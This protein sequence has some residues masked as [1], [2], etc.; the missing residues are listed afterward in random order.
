VT[1]APARCCL[2]LHGHLPWVHHPAH[3]DFLEEDWYFEACVETYLPLLFIL[4]DLAAAGVPTPVAIG[5]TP[6]LLEMFRAPALLSKLERHL[7]RRCALADAEVARLKDDPVAGKT[8]R[9]YRGRFRQMREAFARERGDLLGAFRRHQ[10]A[11]RIEILASCATHAVLPLVATEAARRL[12]VRVGVALY[13]EAFGIAPRG[14]WL[15]ECAY[16]PG[17]DRLLSEEGLDYVVFETHGVRGA[18]PTSPFGVHR[19][20]TLPSGLKALGRDQ[21]S[22]RQVWSSA[23]GYPGDPVYREL[24]RD[25]GF[26]APYDYVKPWL[27]ADGL[28]RNV[29][30]KYHRV[31]GKVELHRKEPYDVD[32][33]KA[34]AREHAAHFL[35]SRDADAARLR[36]RLGAAPLIAAPY[37]LELFGHW[38][39]EGPWFLEA[40]F[41]RAAERPGGVV[42]STPSQALADG[43]PAPRAYAHL[44]TWGKN[45]FLEMWCG[46]ETSWIVRHQHE[47]ERRLAER[48]RAT[49]APTPRAARILDQMTREL[50]LAQ[51]SDWAFILSMKTSTHYAE[52][53]ARGHVARFLELE[54]LLDAPD[55]SLE[56]LEEAEADDSLFPGLSY[57]ALDGGP[58]IR[59][60][61]LGIAPPPSRG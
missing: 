41:R 3:A 16:A 5:L 15:P 26:D 35:D 18:G 59:G 10:V 25:L 9:H 55:A 24:Y 11:G 19:P 42:L 52:M 58:L 47:L 50:L 28:R 61:R 57:R 27:H 51:S 43:G 14:F 30:F 49:P 33:A 20:L 17:V 29:G 34:R 4:D 2:V 1:P 40:L 45:G 56:A 54:K 32:A 37:D 48:V 53:R 31:T 38:W 7:D 13:R 36:D 22:G 39:H 60:G 12:Q 8:A 46:P 6:P 23:T 44:S 21:A